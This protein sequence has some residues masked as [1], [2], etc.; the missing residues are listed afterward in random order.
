MTVAKIK[1]N[2]SHA[3]N[4]TISKSQFVR[5]FQCPKALWLFRNRK[6]LMPPTD[7][8]LQARFDSG[9][10]IGQLAQQYFEDGVEVKDG[11][12]DIKR[13]AQTTLEYIEQGHDTIYE[14]CAIHPTFGSYSFI[15][16]LRKVPAS[17]QWDMIEVK[18][19]TGVKD[20][21][22]IDTSFQRHVFEAA[23]YNIRN[24]YMMLID[25]TYVRDGDI[26]PQGLFKL[27]DI[28][29]DILALQSDIEYLTPQLGYLIEQKTQPDAK[30]GKRC[31]S[32]FECDFK[33]HCWA[34]VPDY[35]LYN[36]YPKAKADEMA[37]LLDSYDVM[38]ITPDTMPSGIKARDVQIYQSN[39]AEH[40]EPNAVASFLDQLQYPLY[41][42]DYETVM[43]GIPIIDGTRP[44]Q[45]IPFQFSC[46]V[47]DNPDA[48]LQHHEFLHKETT[49]P[50][51]AFVQS[52]IATCGDR[53]S[54]I[55]YNRPF[56]A[57]RN[58]DLAED[59]PEYAAALIAINERM[60][61]LM[62][63]F[64]NRMVYRPEQQ[65]SYS[66]KRVLPAFV[67]EL[68][69]KDMAIGDGSAAMEIYLRFAKGNYPADQ[70]DD[71]WANLSAYCELD[72]LAMVKLLDVLKS[73]I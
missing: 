35:N 36:I 56:E 51:E 43:S 48:D 66:I 64:K 45:Q 7:P 20:Y 22:I 47:Q 13:A 59:F 23:G 62:I 55:V 19:A 11:Y 4:P 15:D 18:G 69:Y 3:G 31:F 38:D 14:A 25:N 41:F 30:I 67:P 9:N 63:P 72:T 12:K 58:R 29:Q 16:I 61:D 2:L 27:Q 52:L 21:H 17:D 34:H 54:V 70:L 37:T 60:V 5:G 32:P 1:E 6:E 68:S 46:H 39:A 33:D 73:K 8:A 57:S 42:L 65:S 53:G 44:Y 26:D 49:D 28:T 10:E 71:L 50:R 24:A 40:I